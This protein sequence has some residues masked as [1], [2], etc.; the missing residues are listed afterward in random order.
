M[1]EIIFEPLNNFSYWKNLYFSPADLL[2]EEISGD[3]ADPDLDGIKNKAEYAFVL[4]PWYPDTDDL[5]VG[6][7]ENATGGKMFVLEYFRRTD[8]PNLSYSIGTSIKLTTWMPTNP[9]NWSETVTALIDG[10][11]EVSAKRTTPLSSNGKAF[12]RV[13]VS[14]SP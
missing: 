8:D 13:E 3:D 14:L 1:D 5:P 9:A 11:E 2:D 4:H 10:V 7:I 6:N 12:F